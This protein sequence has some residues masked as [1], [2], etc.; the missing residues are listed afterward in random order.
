MWALMC[1]TNRNKV[2]LGY[3]YT[4]M[5]IQGRVISRNNELTLFSVIS[6]NHNFVEPLDIYIYIYLQKRSGG[7]MS[8]IKR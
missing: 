4:C 1:V 3:I 7:D 8:K 6:N 2:P 5:C